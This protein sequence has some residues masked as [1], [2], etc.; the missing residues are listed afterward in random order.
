MC[1]AV[2]TYTV[3]LSC[4]IN[5]LENSLRISKKAKLR[6]GPPSPWGLGS[7]KENSIPSLKRRWQH[8]NKPNNKLL[9][10]FNWQPT[11]LWSM[12]IA[13]LVFSWS[14]PKVKEKRRASSLM[15]QKADD[16][17]SILMPSSDNMSL[18]NY[19]RKTQE[20]HEPKWGLLEQ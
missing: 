13:S 1:F 4:R 19:K 11:Y 2:Q 3:F 17:R 12:A 5:L 10:A 14:K 9:E 7:L 16:E 18:N 6:G 8:D 20:H 15:P